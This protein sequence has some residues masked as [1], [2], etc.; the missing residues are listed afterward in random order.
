[1][2]CLTTTTCKTLDATCTADT[3]CKGYFVCVVQCPE[4]GGFDSCAV[5]TSGCNGQPNTD[6]NYLNVQ[7]C[8]CTGCMALCPGLC[9]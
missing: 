6:P 8:V 2:A 9:P 3:G 7:T 1:V 4:D 5:G